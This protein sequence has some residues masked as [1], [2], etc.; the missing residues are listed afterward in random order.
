LSLLFFLEEENFSIPFLNSPNVITLRYI[1]ISS[2]LLIQV[3]I[4]ISEKSKKNR[5]RLSI[6][7]TLF[8]D[9][10]GRITQILSIT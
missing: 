2:N 6:V 10:H 5:D 9:V 3:N 8:G 4:V 7:G 1:L